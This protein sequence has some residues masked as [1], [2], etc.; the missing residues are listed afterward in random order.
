ML[1][2]LRRARALDHAVDYLLRCLHDRALPEGGK[3]W[4][5]VMQGPVLGRIDFEMPAAHGRAARRVE[6][7]LRAQ[8]GALANG[9]GGLLEVSCLVAT[10]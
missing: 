7:E 6:Q 3:L 10:E 2:L 1:G 8:R 9:H 5:Q 4:Q